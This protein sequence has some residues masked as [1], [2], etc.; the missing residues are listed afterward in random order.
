M[1]QTETE[2]QLT[3]QNNRLSYE[4][5]RLTVA[6]NLLILKTTHSLA[7]NLCSD[8]RD[9][10]AG[11]SC[12]ACDVERL[13]SIN[14][15][16]NNDIDRLVAENAGLR[17]EVAAMEANQKAYVEIYS[18]FQLLLNERKEL[19]LCLRCIHSAV[20]GACL[21]AKDTPCIS[22]SRFSKDA[23]TRTIEREKAWLN[24]GPTPNVAAGSHRGNAP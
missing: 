22:G 7:N 17:A 5:D 15:G 9:K 16:V 8:H 2:Y 21:I 20:G 3:V 6:N 19:H 23:V 12:L 11:K 18:V 24:S 10:Q 1:S 4:V 14:H 13:T